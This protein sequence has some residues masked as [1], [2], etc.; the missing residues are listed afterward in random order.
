MHLVTKSNAVSTIVTEC[1]EPSK[2]GASRCE[3]HCQ[4]SCCSR[5]RCHNTISQSQQRMYV[6]EDLLCL[7]KPSLQPAA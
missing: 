7:Q 1:H 3:S 4:C 2:L 5:C 6:C